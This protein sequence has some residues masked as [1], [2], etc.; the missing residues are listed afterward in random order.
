MMLIS[1]SI[2]ANKIIVPRKIFRCF[3][4]ACIPA[5]L[6]YGFSLIFLHSQGFTIIQIL[7]DPAQ[8]SG[9]S[10]FLG[11]LSNIGIWL[12]IS[13]AAISFFRFLDSDYIENTHK[14]LLFL[15]GILSLTLAIDDFFM[16]HDLYVNQKICYLT[17]G[18]IALCI[19]V[20]HY[21]TIIEIDGFSFLF[22]GLLLALSIST[23]LIQ[24]Y[25]PLKYTY[26][27]VFEEG[28]KFGGAATWLYFTY[29]VASHRPCGGPQNPDNVLSSESLT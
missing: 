23:D 29:C 27:Q 26:S 5:L 25:I 11:F 15:V 7:R 1:Y 24:S 14:E 18:F 2:L 16:I 9:Q 22:A 4:F 13:S 8:Q 19:L 3:L 28:F 6:F 17:Y 10:S 12:W 21:K 20:R